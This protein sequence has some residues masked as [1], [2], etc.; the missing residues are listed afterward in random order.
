[1][2]LLGPDPVVQPRA[3]TLLWGALE[4]FAWGQVLL[5][6]RATQKECCQAEEGCLEASLGCWQ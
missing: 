1:M 3:S 5:A 2:L 4:W 6:V